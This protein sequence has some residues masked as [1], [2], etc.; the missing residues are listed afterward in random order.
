M[1][2]STTTTLQLLARVWAPGSFTVSLFYVWSRIVSSVISVT[3][4]VIYLLST[5]IKS[6]IKQ[7]A[8]LMSWTARQHC[9]TYNCPLTNYKKEIKPTRQLSVSTN[10]IKSKEYKVKTT[11]INSIILRAFC[12]KISVLFWWS[13]FCHWHKAD[14]DAIAWYICNIDWNSLLCHNPSALSFW[15]AFLPRDAL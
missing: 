12:T 3:V 2:G 10:L 11:C 8:Q 4:S 9:C 7:H 15:S 6:I 1:T 13:T 5:I 14:Y